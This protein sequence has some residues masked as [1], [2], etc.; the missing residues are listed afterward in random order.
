MGAITVAESSS[1]GR[2]ASTTHRVRGRVAGAGTRWPRRFD[3]TFLDTEGHEQTARAKLFLPS[4]VHDGTTRIPLF[5]AAGYE[6]D[7]GSAMAHVRRGFVVV[8]P[9]DLKANPLVQTPNPDVALLHI[10]RSL[11][12]VDDARV[13][14]GGG[15]AGGYM[16]LMLAAETFPL[17]GAAADVPPV[18]WGYN[19]AY[20]LQCRKWSQELKP[21]ELPVFAAVGRSQTRRLRSSATTRTMRS[22]F[23]TAHL[24]N[25]T[26]LRAPCWSTGP[27]PTCWCRSTRL[28]SRGCDRLMPRPI[29]PISRRTRRSPS[30]RRVELRTIDVLSADIRT[31]RADGRP[32]QGHAAR[33]PDGHGPSELPFSRTKRW[34]ITILD[35]GAPEPKVGHVKHAVPWSRNHFIDYVAQQPIAVDQ[36]TAVKLHRLMDR[37]AGK[38]WLPTRLKH[39]DRAYSERADVSAACSDMSP[40]ARRMPPT[41]VNCTAASR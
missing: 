23:A 24:L 2:L 1:R 18:N 15:S 27:R 33:G 7:D 37:Y 36:L 20:F 26:P 39:L 25:G 8:S 22:G 41:S 4:S 32:D 10:A 30:H 19:A 11:P 17:S 3:Y 31:V 34:S 14:I 9:R 29:R 13:V 40:R 5:F 16:T 35:E 12:M 28:A 21:A 38:E 6:L